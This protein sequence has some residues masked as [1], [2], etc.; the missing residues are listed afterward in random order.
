MQVTFHWFSNGKVTMTESSTISNGADNLNK[1]Y[2]IVE[3]HY[4]ESNNSNK[5]KYWRTEK[6]L[7]AESKIRKEE[8]VY[9]S[10]AWRKS[11]KYL[12]ICEFLSLTIHVNGKCW[13]NK[14]GLWKWSE[15]VNSRSHWGAEKSLNT[16]LTKLF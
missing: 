15:N 11:I 5:Y 9:M 10:L 2:K 3:E 7:F 14:H 16:N 4:A 6:K 12:K 13:T 1:K 8:G